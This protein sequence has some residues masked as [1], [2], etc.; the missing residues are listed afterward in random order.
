MLIGGPHSRRACMGIGTPAIAGGRPRPVPWFHCAQS[1]SVVRVAVSDETTDV[2]PDSFHQM[3]CPPVAEPAF[4][5]PS[6]LQRVWGQRWGS[7]DEVGILRSVLVR[8]PGREL[9]KIEAGAWNPAA[10]AL[11]D[12]DGGWYWESEE[13]PDLPL[14]AR[15]H[16]GLVAA[17]EDE[18]VEVHFAEPAGRSLHEGDLHT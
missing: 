16:E 14:V 3:L 15:Q 13:P 8:S 17:L 1:F 5:D 2:F 11:V 7:V 6:E 10:R 12:P 9:E 4:E 18:G